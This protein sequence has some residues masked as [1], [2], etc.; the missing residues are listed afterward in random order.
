MIKETKK[1]I[2]CIALAYLG[3]FLIGIPAMLSWQG[4]YLPGFW[5]VNGLMMTLGVFAFPVLFSIK[6]LMDKYK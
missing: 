4:V 5:I 3:F 1:D 6:S 2:I